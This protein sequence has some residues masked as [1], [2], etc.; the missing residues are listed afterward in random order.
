MPSNAS[1]DHH[2]EGYDQLRR[3]WLNRR[4]T[5]HFQDCVSAS[6][7]DSVVEVGAGTGRMLVELAE[8]HPATRFVGIEPL[9]TYVDFGRRLI[10][11]RGLPNVVLHAAAAEAMTDVVPQGTTDL[12]ISSDVL[13]HVES[14]PEVVRNVRATLRSG[15]RWSLVEPNPGNPYVGLFQA[16]SR[17]E[18]NFWPRRFLR[19][20]EAAGLV[21]AER[22]RMFLIPAAVEDP[23]GWLRELES[24]L[25]GAPVLGGAVTVE[26]TAR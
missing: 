4:R 25:E 3:G 13:H 1:H 9:E 6:S 5:Q 20:A 23:P 19:E 2:P 16:L 8:R 10:E 18:R 7:P 12:V 15:G 26:L 24:R 21:A 11:E 17:G 14:M 22:G